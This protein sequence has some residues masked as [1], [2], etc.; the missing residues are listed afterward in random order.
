MTT[1]VEQW[2]ADKLRSTMVLFWLAT[3]FTSFMRDALFSVTVPLVGSLY[4]FRVLLPITAVLYL[5]W[6]IREKEPLFK[7][8]PALE[9]WCYLLSVILLVYGAA[10]LFWAIDVSW[11]FRRLFNLCFDLCFFLLMLR[12]CRNKQVF[13]ATL[14]VCAVALLLLCAAGIYEVFCGGIVNDRYD[15]YLRFEFFTGVYQPAVVTYHNTNDY[16]SA[17]CMCGAMLLAAVGIRWERLTRACHWAVAG[18]FAALYFLASA[19]TARLGI[20]A[21]LL[22]MTGFA[23]FLLIRDRR[24]LWI[25]AVALTA[26]LFVEFACSYIYVVPPVKR[27]LAEL[28]EHRQEQA[29]DPDSSS[30]KEP[31]KLEIGEP[32]RPSLSEEF[33]EEDAETGEKVLRSEN[34]SGGERTLLILHAFR[35]F[36]DSHGLGVGLGNTEQLAREY[37]VVMNGSMYSIHCFIAR[38][39]GDYGIFALIPLC[40]IGLLLLRK[41]WELLG[42]GLR[43]RDPDIAA[44]GVLYLFILLLYPIAST[45]S[46]DAQDIIAMWI[47]LAGVVSVSNDLVP[48]SDSEEEPACAREQSA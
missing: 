7:G 1:W 33:F 13:R 18:A 11:T 6:M 32:N 20:A 4:P 25:V 37:R 23:L 24:R 15:D 14:Y 8:V 48:I 26:V 41:V 10:S 43:R 36:K 3:V 17:L 47:Y 42:A 38:I 34:S 19:S 28:A 12:L 35:C 45:A 9:K 27:Y 2:K 39:I 31:P 29:V 21:T 40:V 5:V 46:S 30:A 22:L 16:V 44:M